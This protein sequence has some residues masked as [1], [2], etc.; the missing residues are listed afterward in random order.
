MLS[1]VLPGAELDWASLKG[2]PFTKSAKLLVAQAAYKLVTETTL[3]VVDVAVT[4]AVV[5]TVLVVVAVEVMVVVVDADGKIV[6]LLVEVEV[7]VAVGAVATTVLV[8]TR[9]VVLH[10]SGT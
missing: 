10:L 4:V 2:A 7:T 9:V 6:V 3:L 8:E 5:K 1:A